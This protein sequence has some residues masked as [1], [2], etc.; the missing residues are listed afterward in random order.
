MA[1]DYST[2]TYISVAVLV[3]EVAFYQYLFNKFF[4]KRFTIFNKAV[5]EWIEKDLGT[6]ISKLKTLK[7]EHADVTDIIDVIDER[8]DI[9]SALDDLQEQFNGL[10]DRAKYGYGLFVAALVLALGS[11]YASN[12]NITPDLWANITSL[13]FLGAI[14]YTGYLGWGLFDLNKTL[15]TYEKEGSLKKIIST[16]T[17]ENSE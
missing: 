10:L 2:I 14:A 4:I 11:S 1:I 8:G 6:F 13:V 7:K 15:V 3:G 17:E 5:N 16:I 9:L 12:L